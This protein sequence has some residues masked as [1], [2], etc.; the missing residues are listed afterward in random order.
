[1]AQHEVYMIFCTKFD[2]ISF[3]THCNVRTQAVY[4]SDVTEIIS[5][6]HFFGNVMA[7]RIVQ[8][9]LMK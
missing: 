5:V 3:I 1:M 9:A 2:L 4:V 7:S 8:M 6:S